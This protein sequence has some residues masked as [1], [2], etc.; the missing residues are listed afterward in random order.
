MRKIVNDLPYQVN[1]RAFLALLGFKTGKSTI[2]E[3][4]YR[5]MERAV[6][7]AR[8]V[9]VPR[10]VYALYRIEQ[11]LEEMV[12]LEKN[13]LLQGKSISKHCKGFSH[14]YLMAVTIGSEIDRLI[15]ESPVEEAMIIDA[16]GSEAVEGAAESLNKGIERESVHFGLFRFNWRFSPG[17]G[18]LPLETNILFERAL[19]MEE[20]GIR[21]MENL[22]LSPRKSITAI[23]P[24]GG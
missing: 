2:T 1:Q 18:D 15:E 4:M 5:R 19:E 14:V 7:R 12:V 6:E 11:V 22:S 8:N 21:V 10:G 3:T 13:L 20:I 17:Y 9:I 16:Y 23:I 24:A